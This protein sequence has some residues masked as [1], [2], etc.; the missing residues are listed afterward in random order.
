MIATI[1]SVLKKFLFRGLMPKTFPAVRIPDDRIEEKVFLINSNNEL[2]ISKS[3]CVVC[4]RPFLIAV[5]MSSDEILK[6]VKWEAV[7]KNGETISANAQL[8]FHE[9]IKCHA[10][11]LILFSIRSAHCNQ[12][13]FV[14]R[15]L[16][17]RYFK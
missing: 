13:D 5:W 11:F 10:G 4:H 9:K 17:L 1:K 2:E 8:L 6:N 16:I 3:H 12:L 7:I 14:R 15:L